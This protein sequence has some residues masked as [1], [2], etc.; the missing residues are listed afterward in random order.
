MP[1]ICLV[2][3]GQAS[4]GAEDYD[5]LSDLGREQASRVG[6]ELAR[7]GLRNPLVVPGALRRQRDTASLLAAAAGW[8]LSAADPRF[9]EYDH[10]DLLRRYVP[11]EEAASD[12]SSRDVQPLLDQALAELRAATTD[13][14]TSLSELRA[15]LAERG[16]A[17]EIVKRAAELERMSDVQVDVGGDLVELPPAVTA[18]CSRVIGEAMANAV[19]HSGAERVEVRLSS[20]GGV[21]TAEVADDGA[22][23]PAE[24]RAT[25]NGVRAMRARAAMIG[26]RLEIVSGNGAGAASPAVDR[27][28]GRPGTRVRLEVPLAGSRGDSG[29]RRGGVPAPAEATR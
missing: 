6:E 9:D 18:H 14:E 2:R 3:H 13:I 11:P 29:K 24:I 22:G 17:D 23:F 12:G 1:L 10:L 19:R 26:G 27:S 21:F 15:P 7:R 4:F 5:V 8:E 28:D 20:A 25:S 16:L